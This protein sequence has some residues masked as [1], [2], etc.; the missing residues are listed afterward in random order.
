MADTLFETEEIESTDPIVEPFDPSKINVVR[1][2]MSIFQVLRKIRIGEIKLD[3]EFQRNIV[4]DPTRKSRLIESILLKIPLPAFYLDAVEPNKW[5]V[6]DGLQRLSTLD[7]YVNQEFFGLKGLEF[8]GRKL[9]GHKFSEIPRPNQRD[10][11]ETE[12]TLYIIRPETPPNVKFTIFHRINTGGMVLTAQEIRH[13]TFPGRAPALLR[14]LADSNEFKTATLFSVRAKRMDDREC[15]LRHIA[16]RIFK[17]TKY[18]RADLNGML[19]N[20]MTALNE[21]NE[22]EIEKI[23]QDFLKSMRICSTIFGE[24]AFRKFDRTKKSRGPINKAL[25]ESWSTAVLDFDSAELLESREAI[26]S[27]LEE[28]FRTDTDYLK[29]LSLATGGTTAISKRFTK[30]YQIL[31]VGPL[32]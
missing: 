19:S 2:S 1:Q 28:A 14:E 17:Y 18:S 13:A 31:D 5:V 3:P 11:E 30:A 25:F 29:S 24:Y 27:Q 20:A 12:L 7:E 21:A 8:L 22:T 23:K 4:W 32:L 6:V 16:F 9:E 26:V 15:V 10:L